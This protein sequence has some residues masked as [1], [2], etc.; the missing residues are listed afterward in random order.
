MN[1]RFSPS[2][3]VP[4]L[5]L[6]VCCRSGDGTPPGEGSGA[7]SGG[8]VAAAA[9]RPVL[10]LAPGFSVLHQDGVSGGTEP[11]SRLG[12]A[13]D[14]TPCVGNLSESPDHTLVVESTVEAT[15]A[16]LSDADTTLVV[17]GP[18]GLYC[19]DDFEGLNPGLRASLTP[20]TWS[21]Y[22]GNFSLEEGPTPYTLTVLPV[23]VQ[24][25][26]PASSG[27]GEGTGEGSGSGS[28]PG[29]GT[30]TGMGTGAL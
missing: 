4:A 14:G 27:T 16:V 11:A 30:G 22:V 24:T 12:V 23:V 6:L 3:L 28:L 13:L 8:E 29:T 9:A 17:Q 20:G 1:R 25:P 21:V 19:N 2:V 10:T 15:L 18:G 7:P 26:P 5:V